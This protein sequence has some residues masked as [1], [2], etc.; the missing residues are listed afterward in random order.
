[1]PDSRAAVYLRVSDPSQ[2]VS[3]QL[4]ALEEYIKRRGW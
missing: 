3:N 4:P 2:D 1:M